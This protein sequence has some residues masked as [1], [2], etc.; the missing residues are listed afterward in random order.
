L[1]ENE[2]INILQLIAGF[3][4]L[5]I[6]GLICKVLI[7]QKKINEMDN[8][9]ISYVITVQADINEGFVGRIALLEAKNGFK[10]RR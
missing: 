2:I 8:K 3:V 9:L 6:L 7:M 1:N 10:K 4:F 5:I